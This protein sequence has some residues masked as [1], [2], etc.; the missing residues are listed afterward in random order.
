MRRAPLCVSC[1]VLRRVAHRLLWNAPCSIKQLDFTRNAITGDATTNCCEG[2]P[3][4]NCC[5]EVIPGEIGDRWSFQGAA[6]VDK[7]LPRVLDLA[8]ARCKEKIYEKTWKN[9][10]KRGP[11]QGLR[12][13]AGPRARRLEHRRRRTYHLQLREQRNLPGRRSMMR[14]RS[15]ELVRVARASHAETFKGVRL[16]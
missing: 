12:A 7:Q 6:A 10:H 9:Q 8:Q 2:N 15:V 4:T 13:A 16:D 11:F 1:F 3:K 14:S 5:D